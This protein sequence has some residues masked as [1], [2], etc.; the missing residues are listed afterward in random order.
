M[1]CWS[2]T[3][4]WCAHSLLKCPSVLHCESVFFV[5]WVS[6]TGWSFSNNVTTTQ[7]T[8]LCNTLLLIDL[9]S[10]YKVA[11]FLLSGCKWL[12][13]GNTI[14]IRVQISECHAAWRA[15]GGWWLMKLR[16]TCLY[17]TTWQHNPPQCSRLYIHLLTARGKT[18]VI[19]FIVTEIVRV[20]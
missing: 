8:H 1:T 10:F 9:T 13:G 14:N 3:L 5:G 12:Y 6:L 11:V 15:R 4:T 20:N 17:S 2:V 7:F 16:A 18:Y 19:H